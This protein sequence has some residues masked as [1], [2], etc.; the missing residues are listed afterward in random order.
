MTRNFSLL[1]GLLLLCTACSNVKETPKGQAYTL[2]RKGDGKTVKPNQYLVMNMLFKDPKDSVWFDSKK[3]EV[4]ATAMVADT[5]MIKREEGLEDIFRILSKGDSITFRVQAKKLFEKVFRAPLPPKTDPA[6][7]FF[8]A[9]GVKD[10]LSREEF[11]K[12]QTE[13][14]NKQSAKFRKEQAVQLGKDTVILDTYLKEKNIETKKM[15]S[16]IRYVITKKGTGPDAQKGQTVTVN[17]V[18]YL[19]NGK[20]FDTSLEAVAKKSGLQ[21]RSKYDPYKITL[22]THRV[23]EGW[24]QVLQVMNKG[25]K[26]TAYIPSTLAYGPQKRSADIIENS[27]LVF[28]LDVVDITK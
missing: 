5:A 2:V 4:P 7:E 11:V 27:I 8:F 28:D 13:I 19:L 26:I 9:V 24:E 1:T 18:G 10:I 23:I 16:G 20:V 17:Y 22:G 6:S 15:P 3:A 12:L 14:G 25:S 21:P